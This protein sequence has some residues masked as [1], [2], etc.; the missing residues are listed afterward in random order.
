MQY[1]L[2][3]IGFLCLL[4]ATIG[5]PLPDLEPGISLV[6]R[7]Y[8]VYD[9]QDQCCQVNCK[10]Q[11]VGDGNMH[12]DWQ[13]TQVTE[14][15]ACNGESCNV[16]YTETYTT[17]WSINAGVNVGFFTGGFAVSESFA[18]GDTNTCD[19]VAGDTVCVW[20]SVAYA[21]YTVQPDPSQPIC[22]WNGNIV[23]RAPLTDNPGQFYCVKNACRNINDN[24]WCLGEQNPIRLRVF[25]KKRTF[26]FY[27]LLSACSVHQGV[28]AIA[29]V[30]DTEYVAAQAFLDDKHEGPGYVS[31]NDNNDYTLGKV[32]RHNVVIA[33]LPDGEYGTASA[34]IVARDML[35]SFPNVRIGLMV[36]IGGGVPTRQHDI[37]LGDIVSFQTTGFLNQPP[38]VLRTAISGLKAQY[39]SEGH[40]LE[41]AINSVLEKKARLWK[42]YKRPDPGNDRLYQSEITH[43]PNDVTSCAIICGDNLLNLILRPERSEVEDNPEIHY[44]LVASANQL[45]KDALVRDRLAAEKDVL[46]FEMETA[47]LMNHFPCL[48]IR[49]I[50]DYSDSHKNKEWQGYVA[51]TAAAYA[52]DLLCRMP[53]NKVEAEKR[54]GDILSI[55]PPISRIEVNVDTMRYKLDKD[56]DIKILDWLTQVDYGPQQTDYI[57]RRQ[58]GTGQWLLDSPGFQTWLKTIKQTLFCPGILG[59]GKTILTAIATNDL[60]TRFQNDSCIRI[61]YLYCNFWR[62]DEQKAKDLLM[63]LLKQLTQSQSSLPES[64]KSL[65]DRHRDKRTRPLLD[66][67]SRTLQS[68]AGIYSRVFLIVDALD[69]CQVSDGN[70]TRFLSTIFKLQSKCNAN[71]FAT[72]RINDEIAS[73]FVGTETLKIHATNEDIKTYLNGRLLPLQPDIFDSS[74]R[75]MIMSE[76]IKAVDGMFLLA[77]LHMNTLIHLPTKGH[78]KQALQNLAK[79]LKGLDETYQLAMERIN[80]YGKQILAWIVHTTRPLS[81]TELRHALAVQR[82]TTELDKEFLPSVQA[83]RSK[84]AGLVTV[85]EE[86]NIVRLVHYTTQEYFERK[87][88]YWFLNANIDITTICI[89]YLLFNVFERG[90]CLTDEEFEERLQSN[91]FFEYAAQ[92][93]GHYARVSSTEVE[94][95]ILDLLESEAKVSSSSQAMMVSRS[96]Y[97]R[98]SERVPKQMTGLHLAAYFGLSEAII[99]LL[100]R[101]YE[102][103]SKNSYYRTPLSYATENGHEAVVKLLLAK[104]GV[105]LNS[106][107]PEARS[108]TL[109]NRDTIRPR[110]R[111]VLIPPGP[112]P[113]LCR[114]LKNVNLIAHSHF[115]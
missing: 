7:Q 88:N 105:D 20:R 79:G 84:C 62:R 6:P 72:S 12:I 69:E 58:P 52:K 24:Y 5:S 43:P 86:S 53:P 100:K 101:E 108:V 102:P 4:P 91:P 109:E 14:P 3:L 11:N 42:K 17:Q 28:V 68:V 77:E 106:K 19:G 56:E 48:V 13:Y 71:I 60:N 113:S 85:D 9:P 92:N 34:A 115:L 95:L 61:A 35:H 111:L 21:A 89:T 99:A 90:L 80:D 23:M 55:L 46:C 49:G 8:Q 45:M 54:I 32:G 94:Q 31:P 50:C 59:A 29:D 15:L 114:S 40:Q 74:I 22:N 33:V 37:R 87:Q 44:G 103:D 30:S 98:Y 2:A 18:Q 1:P 10:V 25:L 73:L 51:M 38:T 75:D 93:W 64:V 78:I 67:I 82:H 104:D 47:G 83:L 70:R 112:L 76:I 63:S 65:Y 26:K 41:A 96:K 27:Q 110:A 107:D 66:E 81:T 97:P 36:G 57:R 39:E 16:G